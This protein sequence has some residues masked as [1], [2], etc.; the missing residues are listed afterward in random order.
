MVNR[1]KSS[2]SLTCATCGNPTGRR[3]DHQCVECYLTTNLPSKIKNEDE[4]WVWA[5]NFEPPNQFRKRTKPD[6]ETVALSRAIIDSSAKV[7]EDGKSLVLP[8]PKAQHEIPLNVEAIDKLAV[9]TGILVG[10]WLVYR[11][12]D[13]IDSAWLTIARATFNKKLG[14]G[15]KVSTA[16]R[17]KARHVICIYTRNYLDLDDIKRIRSLLRDMGFT[18]SLCYKP[19]IYTY[20][21]IYSGTTN[22]SP[23]R[24]RE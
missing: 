19:D 17:D 16:E 13:E 3:I 24:Y 21:D 22:L 20:L 2:H 4:P 1:E 8:L 14:I 5:N 6:E 12:R 18:E 11:P 15:A 7:S 23:C 9:R 10:K